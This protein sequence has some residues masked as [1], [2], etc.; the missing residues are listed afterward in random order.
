MDVKDHLDR[1][2]PE[3]E[4]LPDWDAVVRDARPSRAR[5][6]APRLAIVGAVVA[7]AALVA[8]AP[9][10]GDEPAGIL[11]RALAAVGEGPVLHVVFRFE[12]MGTIVDLESGER[13]AAYPEREVWW[14]PSRGVHE[15][16]SVA[17]IQRHEFFYSPQEAG[18]RHLVETLAGFTTGYRDALESGDAVVAR[19]GVV[20]GRPVHWIRWE[21]SDGERSWGH[22]VA[23]DRKTAEPV[24]VHE[25]INGQPGPNSGA[26]VTAFESLAAGQ[27]DFTVSPRESGAIVIMHARFSE[28]IGLGEAA[29]VLGTT[30]FWL[31]PMHGGLPLASASQRSLPRLTRMRGSRG[32]GQNEPPRT[33]SAV[34]L[35]YGGREPEGQWVELLQVRLVSGDQLRVGHPILP[36]GSLFL[37]GSYGS[38]RKGNLAV[39][40]EGSSPELV[41]SAAQALRPLSAGSGGGG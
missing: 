26:T 18:D 24:Y 36:E 34:S 21:D 35:R 22:E 4:R 39:V 23:V 41:V 7:L 31:G 20:G 8:V 25:L 11:D 37:S 40:I 9:W 13:R 15:S 29:A 19:E 38:M 16:W 17:G 28:R 14:D 30:A 1:M 3:T 27:G 12:P 6:A 32:Y 2:T 5:W 10:R 33:R